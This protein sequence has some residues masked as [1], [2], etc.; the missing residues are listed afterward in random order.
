MSIDIMDFSTWLQEVWVNNDF[1]L[2]VGS[3]SGR[4]DPDGWYYR[5]YHSEGAWNHWGYANDEV[6]QLVEEGR[7]TVGTEERA[8]IYS[9]IQSIVSEDLP[10]TYLYFRQDLTGLRNEVGGYEM[11][12]VE[13]A[14]FHETYIED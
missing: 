1:E 6:D 12:P 7:T 11:T 10:M 8:E 5:Q 14:T 2:S 3:W 9:Q 13:Q 4:I